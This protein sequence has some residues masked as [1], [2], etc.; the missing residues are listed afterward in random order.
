M[1]YPR[2]KYRYMNEY[3]REEAY[4]K[5]TAKLEKLMVDAH[6][7]RVEYRIVDITKTTTTEEVNL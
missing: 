5:A 2:S 6:E 1:R 3:D 7:L 4:K